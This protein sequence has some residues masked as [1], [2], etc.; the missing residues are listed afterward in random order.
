[1][2]NKMIIQWMKA[3]MLVLTIV[4][5]PA[6]I[7]EAAEEGQ[8]EEICGNQTDENSLDADAQFEISEASL[9]EGWYLENNEWYYYVQDQKVFG[10]KHIS[11]YWYYFDEATGAMQTGLVSHHGKGRQPLR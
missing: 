9:K 6:Q 4:V 10:E 7:V 8:G 1:M 11:G 2:S 3:F 5:A